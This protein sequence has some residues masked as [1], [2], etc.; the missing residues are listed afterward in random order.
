MFGFLK[1]M[2]EKEAEAAI[3]RRAAEMAPRAVSRAAGSA[4]VPAP[5]SRQSL[6]R[7]NASVPEFVSPERQALI[8]QAVAVVRAKRQILDHLD[9]ETRAKLVAMAITTFLHENKKP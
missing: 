8:Q 5:G 1:T 6:N 7:L 3:R 4:A 9:D 2:F